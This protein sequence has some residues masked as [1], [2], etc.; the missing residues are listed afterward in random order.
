MTLSEILTDSD[1]IKYEYATVKDIRSRNEKCRRCSYV[2]R[3]TGG[4]RN[5]AL[6]AGGDYYSIDPYL[7]EFFENG[8]DQRI[9]DIAQPAFEAYLKRN[10]SV[11]KDET[12]S[13]DD[14][15]RNC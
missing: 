3:C 6:I 13:L 2:D 9:R 7:C 11:R 5:S 1:L 10:P 14:N 8:W 4:C 12:G 15:I